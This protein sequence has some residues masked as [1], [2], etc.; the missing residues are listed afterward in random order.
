MH[1]NRQL[2]LGTHIHRFTVVS[3]SQ[4]G[5]DVFEEEDST[6]VTS[7]HRED[8]HRVERDIQRFDLTA[9]ALKQ[10][11]WVEHDHARARS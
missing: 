6:E 8:W 9:I 1:L 2:I 10:A 11:G 5:W 4:H 7:V 3:S